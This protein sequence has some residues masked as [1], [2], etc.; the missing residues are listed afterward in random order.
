MTTTKLNETVLG[1]DL[2]TSSCKAVIV[3]VGSG[4]VVA[5]GSAD[6]PVSSR[7]LGQA[8]TDPLVW[9][10]AIG[11]CVRQAVA[12]CSTT[13]SAIGL[14]GQMHGLVL[15]D[16]DAV[17]VR[18]AM[19]WADMRAVAEIV[20]YDD[21]SCEQRTRLANPLTPGMAGPMLV[22]VASHEPD[23]Y[24][25]ARW[26]LQP[27]DWVRAKLTGV[28]AAEPSDASAT[29]LYD[30]PG[31]DWDWELMDEL[32]LRRELLAPLETDSGALA[33]RLTPAAA[34][35]LGL[36]TDIPVAAGAGDSAAAAFGS[37]LTT[38]AQVQLTVGT[39]A[40]V[41]RPQLSPVDRSAVGVHVYRSA[42]PTG[43]YQMAAC[44]N[45]GIALTWVRQALN[46][47]WQ[48]LYTSL[49]DPIREDD[50]LFIPHLTGERTPYVNP[51]LRASWT[52]LALGHDRVSLLRSALEGVAFAVTDAYRALVGGES[53]ARAAPPA[54]R[55][56]GG[57]TMSVAWRQMLA[58][59]T[60]CELYGFDCPDASGRGAALLGAQA[61]GL[62]RVVDIAGR[63]APRMSL[64][65]A[66]HADCHDLL[67]ARYCQ[68]QDRTAL[69]GGRT[70]FR[71]RYRTGGV[72]A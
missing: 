32:G 25:A 16:N 24:A 48:E 14:S 2:G 42:F 49:D 8:E 3:D 53:E 9:W 23:V 41:V 7:H 68:F 55:V 52:G 58:D 30:L 6:Y 29:L 15:C 63:L 61:A 21:L 70:D 26:A 13:V 28:I 20:R 39:G 46:A 64:I 27:K 18:S 66:P 62:V 60:G 36:A 65:A 5:Q 56:A 45:A 33:G 38:P 47:S 22:W 35:H 31:D 54:L 50:P 67:A 11:Y 37:G 44:T 57:G 34:E 10:E 40:Q 71:R 4:A 43:W 19:L 59:L 1:I 72:F 17:P 51:Q 12:S 69:L